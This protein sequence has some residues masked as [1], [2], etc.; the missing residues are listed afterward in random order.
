MSVAILSPQQ[1]SPDRR[2]E[3]ALRA[4]SELMVY[5]DLPRDARRTVWRTYALLHGCRSPETVALMER[6]QG[7][8]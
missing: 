1:P 8:R 4:L 2:L 3:T 5:G 7:L 6:Q